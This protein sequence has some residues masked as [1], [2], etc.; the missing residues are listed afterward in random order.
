MT[1]RQNSVQVGWVGL[2]TIARWKCPVKFV[3]SKDGF[4][5]QMSLLLK[6]IFRQ[7]DFTSFDEKK[8]IRFPKKYIILELKKNILQFSKRDEI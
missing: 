7:N 2:P 8:N 4:Y 6:H 1:E 3:C 5:Q